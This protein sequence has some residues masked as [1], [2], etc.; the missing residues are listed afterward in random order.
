VGIG[1]AAAVMREYIEAG[2]SGSAVYLESGTSLSAANAALASLLLESTDS[3]P[4]A[5]WRRCRLY[6]A[7][8]EGT[9]SCELSS[10]L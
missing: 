4:E 1:E 7:S 3:L 6:P 9:D 2:V 8:V 5:G 10:P